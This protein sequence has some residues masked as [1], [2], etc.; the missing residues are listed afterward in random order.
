MK[1]PSSRFFSPPPPIFR[2]ESVV[3][4]PS[5]CSPS[6]PVF[7]FFRCA[8]R[9][10]RSFFGFASAVR[11]RLPFCLVFSLF[12]FVSAVLPRHRPR[13]LCSPW[14]PF[15][16]ASALPGCAR[17]L[18]F[19]LWS[20]PFS[21]V[22]GFVR[23]FRCFRLGLRV[24]LLSVR[25]LLRSLFPPAC[26]FCVSLPRSPSPLL[27][28]GS[29]VFPRRGLPWSSAFCLVWRLRLLRP[30]GPYLSVFA[31][32]LFSLSWS[33]T[34]PFFVV[35]AVS[36]L[37]FGSVVPLRCGLP[38]RVRAPLSFPAS[39]PCP[40]VSAFP[41]VVAF[42]VRRPP[43]SSRA[44]PA[45]PSACPFPAPVH[46]SSSQDGDRH[47]GRGPSSSSLL[48]QGTL[49]LASAFP[50]DARKSPNA[51]PS[52]QAMEFGFAVFDAFRGESF[53]C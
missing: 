1:S 27:S 47:C 3:R 5:S 28:F 51:L 18:P 36:S 12:A 25:T 40:F 29:A 19:S 39:S 17:P 10:R 33:P 32:L 24:D 20:L 52:W 48:D 23:R 2:L 38:T 45:M 35:L 7:A 42:V 53:S 31:P 13:P 11:F 4:L 15:S 22:L 21:S 9:L 6:V 44:P 46:L 49:S 8:R 16:A 26:C 37:V 34:S 30:S 50:L 41:D 14:S 43:P